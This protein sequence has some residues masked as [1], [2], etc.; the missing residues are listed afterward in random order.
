MTRSLLGWL[1]VVVAMHRSAKLDLSYGRWQR[2]TPG[3]SAD[4]RPLFDAVLVPAGR[5]GQA[6]ARAAATARNAGSTLVALVAGP[7]HAVAAERLLHGLLGSRRPYVVVDSTAVPALRLETFEQ[8]MASRWTDVS[9]RRN[10]GL[11]LAQLMGWDTVLFVDDDVQEIPRAELRRGAEALLGADRGGNPRRA[12]GWAFED[13]PDLSS[14]GHALFL[15]QKSDVRFFGG[16]AIALSHL[17]ELPFFPPVYNEDLLFTMQVL[18]DDPG[19]ACVVGTLGQDP[20]R[21]FGDVDRA[22]RQEFGELLVLGAVS[23]GLQDGD[24]DFW[25]DRLHDRARRLKELASRLTDTDRPAESAA[26]R[27][28]L[29]R[30]REDWPELLADFT[31][32]WRRDLVTWRQFRAG[33]PRLDDLAQ[34]SAFLRD[35]AGSAGAVA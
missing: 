34:A 23:G 19:S 14:V 6:I 3:T 22:A 15:D 10:V 21:P 26:V 16:G 5:G 12:V 29:A 8:A 31:T 17:P 18:H 32:R 28:A 25:R 2:Q 13:F 27:A 35:S 33:L 24:I 30:H 20:Y 7:E 4:P 11:V 1:A 9:A